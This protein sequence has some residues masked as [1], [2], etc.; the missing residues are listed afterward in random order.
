MKMITPK[1]QD[2][3]I[4]DFDGLEVAAC[5]EVGPSEL[6]DGYTERL[7]SF[8]DLSTASFWTVY[9]HCIEGG[10]QA[11]WDFPSYASAKAWAI[12]LMAEHP[13][14]SKHGVLYYNNRED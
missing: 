1:I 12:E 3:S 7:E 2:L 10:A 8:D 9:G 13:C 5:I 6:D 11:L 4:S 14:L